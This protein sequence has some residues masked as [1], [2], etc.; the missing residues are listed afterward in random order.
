MCKHESYDENNVCTNCGETVIAIATITTDSGTT[1]ANI[2]NLEDVL[3][4]PNSSATDKLD[5]TLIS[6]Y[7]YNTGDTTAKTLDV[8]RGTYTIDLNGNTLT[9]GSEESLWINYIDANVTIKNGTIDKVQLTGT[10]AGT[11]TMIG[12]LKVTTL[13]VDEYGT[14]K[15]AGDNVT[16]TT[17]DCNSGGKPTLSGGTYDEIIAD[18]KGDFNNMLAEGYLFYD[19]DNINIIVDSTKSAADILKGQRYSLKNVTVKKCTHENMT[20]N[21]CIDCNQTFV[22]TVTTAGEASSTE[23]FAALAD[24]VTAAANSTGSTLTL[25]DNIGSTESPSDISTTTGIFTID[26]NAKTLTGSI[27]N[28]VASLK[29]KN[30]TVIGSIDNGA[31][32][33]GELLADDYGFNC[34]T[35]WYDSTATATRIPSEAGAAI[36]VAKLPIQSVATSISPE[37]L[38][39]SDSL[40]VELK[41]I[42]VT[43]A[44]NTSAVGSASYA[45]YTVDANGTETPVEGQ[46]N[47]TLTLNSLTAGT[48]KYRCKITV[49]NYTKPVDFDFTVNKATL[50]APADPTANKLNGNDLVFK[51]KEGENNLYTTTGESQQLVSAPTENLPDGCNY[52]Y[53]LGENGTWTGDITT[54]TAADAGTYSV[55][56]RVTGGTNYQNYTPTAPVEVKIAP[57]MISNITVSRLTKTEKTYDGTADLPSGN[58]PTY[59]TEMKNSHG[60]SAG[61]TDPHLLVNLKP[62]VDFDCK[63]EY[64]IY[65]GNNSMLTPDANVGKNK[66]I[67]ATFTLKN[68]NFVFGESETTRSRPIEEKGEITPA[69]LKVSAKEKQ[70]KIGDAVPKLDNPALGTDYTLEGLVNNET[71]QTIG[72]TDKLALDYYDAEGKNKVTPDTSKP[73]TYLIVPSLKQSAPVVAALYALVNPTGDNS[74]DPLANYQLTMISAKFIVTENPKFTITATAGANGSISPLGVTTVEQG[75]AQTYTIT[76]NPGYVIAA[77]KVDGVNLGSIAKYTFSDVTAN[78]T[79]EA[80]FMLPWGN[81]QTGVDVD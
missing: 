13:R 65:V 10:T 7:T 57:A 80:T 49:D 56:W 72:L 4:R 79:I 55:F 48:Y 78:H 67:R 8:R 66:Y 45:W 36:T 53:K 34:G 50:T 38:T 74:P 44:D 70:V 64:A 40:S 39:Y 46:T 14:L 35:T 30:G 29:L 77:V 54:V 27:T 24:A 15:V 3:L 60:S 22:A 5:I 12:Q 76:P 58:T 32:S 20:G 62:G 18:S 31:A 17:L 1:T 43:D 19:K 61:S 52:E 68:G 71:A 51:P 69:P 73:G 47:A 25:L 41:I 9:I 28:S 16:V 33:V 6:N 23:Y 63:L 11:A 26:L 37:N 59:S 2:I 42:D 21:E 75:G 81:P